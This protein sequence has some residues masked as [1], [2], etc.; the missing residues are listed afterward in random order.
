MKPLQGP[1]IIY[2][3]LTCCIINTKIS[4][5]DSLLVRIFSRLLHDIYCIVLAEYHQ[6]IKDAGAFFI[7]TA[8][9][10]LED[11]IVTKDG[12]DALRDDP[13]VIVFANPR[14]RELLKKRLDHNYDSFLR[15]L[16]KNVRRF[17]KCTKE[18]GLGAICWQGTYGLRYLRRMSNETVTLKMLWDDCSTLEREFRRLKIILSQKVYN[19]ILD[20]IDNANRKLRECTHQS[21]LL[22]PSRN[23][24]KSSKT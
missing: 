12:L 8:E 14:Y 2:A 20:E 5:I 7:D 19:Q 15:T 11:I 4:T 6:T 10:P 22:E 9:Q 13:A 3:F 16:Q 1:T 24:I 17:G 21:R 23:R 18:T